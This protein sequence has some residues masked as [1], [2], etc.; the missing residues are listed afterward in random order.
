MDKHQLFEKYKK[1]IEWLHRNVPPDDIYDFAE[2]TYMAALFFLNV[3][4]NDLNIHV[5][6]QNPVFKK[7][8]T[9]II[10]VLDYREKGI[11]TSIDLQMDVYE[12][13]D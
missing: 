4:S 11:D 2:Q 9:N 13:D 12:G 10:S 3:I 7:W 1:N 5:Q 8:A 6:L